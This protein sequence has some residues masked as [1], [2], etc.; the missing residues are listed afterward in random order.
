MRSLSRCNCTIGI[1]GGKLCAVYLIQR[2]PAREGDKEMMGILERMKGIY[3]GSS[4]LSA[5]IIDKESHTAGITSMPA[6]VE[7]TSPAFELKPYKSLANEELTQRIQAV[8]DEL[9]PRL[10][11]LGHHYQQDEVIALA[12]LRGDSYQLSQMAAEST[13]LPVHRVLRRA[14][15]GRD[16]RHP[17]QPAGEAGRARR[18]ARDGRPAR[19][20]RR[21]LDGR[22]GGDRPDRRR[23][24]AAGRS[25]RHRRHHA[26]HVHQLGRQPEGVLSAGTAASS[27]RRATPRRC[28]S[29]RSPAPAA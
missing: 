8:R 2:G 18:R 22:H 11:I 29:G 25:D 15:H 27:A 12:D 20:G 4:D 14:L 24:G 26:G 7:S 16:G 9:G 13:R 28:S 10:L 23:L 6:L 19:H 21:L 1:T 5:P 3:A 17:G